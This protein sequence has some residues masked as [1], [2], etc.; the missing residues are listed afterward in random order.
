MSVFS[1]PVSFFLH[2][3][4]LVTTGWK[5]LRQ[6]ME[7][8]QPSPPPLPPARLSAP[9]NNSRNPFPEPLLL[10]VVLKSSGDQLTGQVADAGAGES[11]STEDDESSNGVDRDRDSGAGGSDGG[12]GGRGRKK[13]AG[14]GGRAPFLLL[15]KKAT[16]L[17]LQPFQAL[18]VR[19]WHPCWSG[20]RIGC[21]TQSS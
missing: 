21:C 17:V 13:A 12:G 1:P 3:F 9:P 2:S 6:S 4:G 11:R 14:A 20:V 16:D 19:C 5:V 10:T 18:Q 7:K 8:K 15:L